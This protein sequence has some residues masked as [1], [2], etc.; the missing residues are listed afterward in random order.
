MHANRTSLVRQRQDPLRARYRTVPADALISDRART[1]NAC[2]KD[3]FHGVVVPADDGDSPLQFGVHR[4]VGGDHDRPNPG[5]LLS[6]ALAACFDSTLR[7]IADHLGVRLEFLEVN[8]DAQCDVRGCLAVDPG[9]PVGF[10]LM[11]C[12]A[13]LRTTDRVD[14]QT[15]GRLV[16][17]AERSCV[18]MQTLRSGVTV[19]T[20]VESVET[21]AGEAV[22]RRDAPDS[23]RTS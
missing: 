4:A 16:A 7:M 11:R 5:D 10:Q 23:I 1:I 3:P 2:G 6:A 13:R 20:R 12:R 14:E 17:A 9:V 15:L 18:V 19:E 8:V 21:A 22:A